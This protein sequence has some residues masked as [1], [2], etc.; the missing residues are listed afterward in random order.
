MRV[1]TK[2]EREKISRNVIENNRGSATYYIMITDRKN[3]KDSDV[4]GREIHRICNKSSFGINLGL[5][6][7]MGNRDR[8]RQNRGVQGK[9]PDFRH[10]IAD[11]MLLLFSGIVQ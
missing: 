3:V 7:R 4:P 2:E 8:V 9:D 6:Y 1:C 11:A 5:D 10:G